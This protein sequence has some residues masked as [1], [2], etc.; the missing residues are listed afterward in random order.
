MSMEKEISKTIK[1]LNAGKV[2]AYPTETVWGIGCNANNV[3]AIE[4]IYAIKKRDKNKPVLVLVDSLTML[5]KFAPNASKLET[6]CLNSIEPTTV[7]IENIASLPEIIQGKNRSVAFRITS[8]EFCK[9]IIS[10]TKKPLVSTS[11]NISGEPTALYRKELSATIVNSVD[12]IINIDEPVL[13]KEQKPSKIVQ[14]K[15]GKLN[16]IRN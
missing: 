14:I 16:L 13:I 12:Y 2:I 3:E 7:I 15:N 10:K 4:K 1:L 5:L 8:H 6:D 11:A 9:N